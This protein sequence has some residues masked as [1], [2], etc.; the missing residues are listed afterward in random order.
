M[1]RYKFNSRLYDEININCN[2]DYLL[3]E[4]DCIDGTDEDAIYSQKEIFEI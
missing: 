3:D 1:K 2:D 4:K